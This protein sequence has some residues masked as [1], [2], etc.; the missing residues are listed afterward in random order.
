[1]SDNKKKKKLKKGFKKFIFLFPIKIL[2]ILVFVW[3]FFYVNEGFENTISLLA[4]SENDNGDISGSSLIDL[5]LRIERGSGDIFVNMNS[6]KD[7]DTQVSIINSQKVACDIFELDCNSYDFYYSFDGNSVLL[8]GPSASSAV[9]LLVAK[10]LEFEK[11]NDKSVITGSLNSGGLIGNVGGVEEKIKLAK[12]KGFKRV[13]VPSF[14]TFNESKD[15]GIEVIS[16]LDIVEAHNAFNDDDFK[17]KTYPINE[18][19][20]VEL[21]RSLADDLC[22]RNSMIEKEIDFGLIEENSSFERYL[23]FAN[24]SLNS[25]RFANLTSDYYSMGSFCYN[26]NTNYRI[27]AD[28][29]KNLSSEDLL[30]EVNTFRNEIQTFKSE[31]K[32]ENYRKEIRTTN[33]FYVYLLLND[34]IE[35]AF[36]FLAEIDKLNKKE[37]EI[38]EILKNVSKIV[39]EIEVNESIVNESDNFYN[40]TLKPLKVDDSRKDVIILFAQAQERYYTVLLWEK[41]IQHIGSEISVK[42]NQVYE[43]CLQIN[44]EISIKTELLKNYEIDV[45]EDLVEKQYSYQYSKDYPLCIYRGLELLGR[46]NT[47]LNSFGFTQDN[48][49]NYTKKVVDFTN[50]RLSMNSNGEF[51]LI[52]YIYS[53]YSNNLLEQNDLFSANLYSN[54][55]LSYADLNLYLEK[56]EEVQGEVNQVLKSLFENKIF[57][58]GI[59]VIIA[60]FGF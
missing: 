6:I 20:Y 41:L 16:V 43:T 23:N 38:E 35:E 50:T 42:Q 56:E 51:P 48:Q 60:F 8:K 3:A 25:S 31:L 4:V 47:V 45:F 28:L 33:D 30:R 36:D 53:E 22:S 32:S 37:V 18:D 5:N 10:T 13:L 44:R 40:A 1:M 27:L 49:K 34:R 17:I 12:K 59:L 2:M 29:Q 39:N 11:L 58:F 7:I 14:S 19:D 21:M 55:A 46:E 26:A 54:Y 57:L 24:K 9:A 15:F 52:P